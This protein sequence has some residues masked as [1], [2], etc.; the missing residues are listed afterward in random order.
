MG[1]TWAPKGETPV[2]R[3]NFGHWDKV[4]LM[5]AVGTN[6]KLHFQLKLGE[7]FCNADLVKFL[8]HL[9][10]KVKGRLVV[11]IDGGG[12]H[13]GEALY[14]FLAKHADRIRVIPLPPYGFEYNPDEGVWGHLKNVELNSFTPKTTPELVHRVRGRLRAMQ[15]RPGLVGSFFLRSKLPRE[16]T[17]LLLNQAGAP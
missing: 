2:L 12:L 13:K 5:S 16:D 9:L 8:K 14:V 15:R 3:H 6:G 1:K 4:N 10:R 7:S 17:E 11:F